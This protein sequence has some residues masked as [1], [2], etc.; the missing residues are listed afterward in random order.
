[1]FGIM[2]VGI[3]VIG[4]ICNGRGSERKRERALNED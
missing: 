4:S 2:G 3:R 1:M